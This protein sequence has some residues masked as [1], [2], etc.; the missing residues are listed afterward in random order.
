MPPTICDQGYRN[1]L[2]PNVV[3]QSGTASAAPVFVTSPPKRIRTRVARAVTT[4]RR[5]TPRFISAAPSSAAPRSRSVTPDAR[6]GGERL[7]LRQEVLA[8]L[9]RAVLV[10]PAIHG[11]QGRPPVEVRRRRGRRPFER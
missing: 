10:G 7:R 8:R 5:W 4:A 6:P 1:M 2:W 9:R 3:G 11:G